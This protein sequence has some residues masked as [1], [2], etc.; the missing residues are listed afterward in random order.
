[1]MKDFIVN[2]KWHN[3]RPLYW[4]EMIV[5]HDIRRI[6]ELGSHEGASMIEFVKA[7][8]STM[9]CIDLWEDD[10]VF[11]RW[12]HNRDILEEKYK[13]HIVPLKC[14]TREGLYDVRDEIGFFDMVY[15]DAS[16]YPEDVIADACMAWPLLKVGGIMLFDDYK[17]TRFENGMTEPDKSPKPAIDA[18]EMTHRRSI[19]PVDAHHMQRAFRKTQDTNLEKKRY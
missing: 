13:A 8:A 17:W 14:D 11:E 4:N 12:T 3:D 19:W 15:V 16:H 10:V 2:D 9:I 5:E 18:F 1:M 6:L 7:G